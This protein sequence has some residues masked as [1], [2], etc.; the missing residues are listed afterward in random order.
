MEVGDEGAAKVGKLEEAAA[1][2]EAALVEEDAAWFRSLRSRSGDQVRRPADLFALLVH[3]FMLDLGFQGEEEGVGEGWR[4]AVGH[5]TRYTLQC[6]SSTFASSTSSPTSTTSSPTT[7]TS[8]TLTVTTLG[9]LV[10]ILGSHADS[11]VT[12][13]TIKLKPSDFV[14]EE[15]MKEVNEVKEAAGRSMVTRNLGSMARLFKDEV[16]L[17]LL[18]SARSRLGLGTQGL[19]GLPPEL[20]HRV[21]LLLPPSPLAALTKVCR[22]LHSAAQDSSLWRRH[23][24]LRFGAARLLHL[25][26]SESSWKQKFGEEVAEVQRREDERRRWQEEV[27]RRAVD[28]LPTAPPDPFG[29]PL[30]GPPGI[31]GGDYDRYPGGL[32]PGLPLFG[33]HTLRPQHFMPRPRFD[34][35]GPGRGGFGGFGGGFGF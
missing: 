10:K 19:L 11:K 21:L 9:P 34:P 35:P 12:F 22:V 25:Q 27:R 30:P 13:S 31:L 4:R 24:L 26:G 29:P 6:P 8:V 33:G 15:E 17:P 28:P 20:L 3:G 32:G 23:F 16:G 1:E 18:Y 5:I 14:T 2:K 7:S